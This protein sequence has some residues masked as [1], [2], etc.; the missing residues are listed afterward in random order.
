MNIQELNELHEKIEKEIDIVISY[1]K[2]QGG[3]FR[4]TV[5]GLEEAKDIVFD[6]FERVKQDIG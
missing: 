2:E 1:Y 4:D 3:K 5:L 6:A